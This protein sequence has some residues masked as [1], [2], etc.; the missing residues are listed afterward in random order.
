M[1]LPLYQN[2]IWP[3]SC[4]NLSNFRVGVKNT[5]LRTDGELATTQ[6]NLW[7]SICMLII[8]IF[9]TSI[10]QERLHRIHL[11]YFRLLTFWITDTHTGELCDYHSPKSLHELAK[12]CSQLH[13]RLYTFPD[14]ISTET[15]RTKRIEKYVMDVHRRIHFT[16]SH[17]GWNHTFKTNP[18]YIFSIL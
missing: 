6:I 18:E 7:K 1:D 5:P 11:P 13:C 8:R 3:C 17:Q 14:T 15:R 10:L 12:S 2:Y 4:F 9:V 16:S